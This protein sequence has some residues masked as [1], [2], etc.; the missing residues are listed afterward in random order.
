MAGVNFVANTVV[1]YSISGTITGGAGATVTLSGAAS[2]STTANASGGYSFSGLLSGSYTVTPNLAGS[3]FSPVSTPVT[4]STANISGINF[5]ANAPLV[6]DV[7]TSKDQTPA[8]TT[9]ASPAFSTATTN[10]LLLAFVSTD[11]I[12]PTA[13]KVNSIS[14]G[15]LTWTLVQRTNSQGGTAEIWRAFAAAKQTNITVT[16]TISQKVASS[17]TIVGFEN[18]DATGA[19]GVAA[20]GATA[21]ASAGSGAPTA[22]LVT[23]RNGSW[24]FGVGNDFDRAT[25]RTVGA[26]QT[27][28]H[29]A[30]SPTGDTYWVQMQTS[31]TPSSVTTVTIND[32]APTQDSWNL[33]ICEILPQP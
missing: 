10:E 21:S 4:I 12:S 23:T 32:T 29:Q 17:M 5:A 19:N 2:A 31:Q 30:T 25:L 11:Q 6:L 26:A 3:T 20:I 8:S 24:V 15:G 14:G 16:A 13:V 9:I 27:M 18:V 33:T 28:V 1:T 7:Q 22:S